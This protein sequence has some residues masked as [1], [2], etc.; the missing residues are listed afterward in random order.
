MLVLGVLM[1]L[2]FNFMGFVLAFALAG[3]STYWPRKSQSDG[4]NPHYNHMQLVKVVF[5]TII[6]QTYPGTSCSWHENCFQFATTSLHTKISTL[7]LASSI[8]GNMGR[9]QVTKL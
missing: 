9:T 4:L 3:I 1:K 8:C 6:K 2:T 5:T 7:L